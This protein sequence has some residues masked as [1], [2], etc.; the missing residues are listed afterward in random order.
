MIYEP[1]DPDHDR[2]TRIHL[3]VCRACDVKVQ[4]LEFVLGQ[5]LL[6]ELAFNDSEQLALKADI[7]QLRANWTGRGG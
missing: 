7:S 4:T 2:Q 3:G 5:K 6:G 1:M